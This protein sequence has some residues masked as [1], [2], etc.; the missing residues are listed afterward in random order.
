MARITREQRF[1]AQ[2]QKTDRCWLWTEAINH[3]G[4]G[5]FYSDH[6]NILAHR[7][8]YEQSAGKVPEGLELHHLCQTRPCVRPD[9]LKPVTHAENIQLGRGGQNMAR[10]TH[11]PQG[12]PYDLFNTYFKPV[13]GRECRECS[14]V[15]IRKARQERRTVTSFPTLTA[16]P[17]PGRKSA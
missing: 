6:R 8:A 7:F 14:R 11:C 15:R 16:A 5:L 12:H 9:H 10:K 4:Y 1:W 13:G 2:V 17:N 3:N